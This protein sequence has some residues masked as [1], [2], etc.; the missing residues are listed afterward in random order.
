M[1]LSHRKNG[2]TSLFKEVRDFKGVNCQTGD[3]GDD[4]DFEWQQV[5]NQMLFDR[6]QVIRRFDHHL[7][8]FKESWVQVRLSEIAA[9]KGVENSGERKHT[10][11]IIGCAILSLVLVQ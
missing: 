9:K 2:L 11:M 10:I 6:P 3:W 7:S 5:H 8:Q 1:P 4:P